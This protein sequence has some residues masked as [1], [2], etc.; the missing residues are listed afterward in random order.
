LPGVRNQNPKE[1]LLGV[2]ISYSPTPAGRFLRLTLS[3]S[4]PR[5]P[6][7]PKKYAPVGG[8]S[9]SRDP[10]KIV[11]AGKDLDREVLWTLHHLSLALPSHIFVLAFSASWA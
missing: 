2:L 1:N 3:S 9:I 4:G 6:H 11:S 5:H 8:P 10:S 7:I